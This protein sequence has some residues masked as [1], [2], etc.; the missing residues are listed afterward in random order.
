[1]IACAACNKISEEIQQDIVI[2]DTVGFEIPV[3]STDNSQEIIQNIP[4]SFNLADQVKNSINN[5]NIT[6][7]K[8]T[9]LKSMVL[10]LMPIQ[11]KSNGKIDSTDAKN[12]FNNLASIKF[13]I[14]TPG[15][16]GNLANSSTPLTG[17]NNLT[18]LTPV[19]VPD[20]L[21]TFLINPASKYEVTIKAKTATTT[22]M[23]VKFAAIY[24]ITLAK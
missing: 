17:T 13:R 23:F 14:T 22:P 19:I 10:G 6:Q 18:P 16:L 9:K 4:L 20:S 5:F 11:R 21:K 24:T 7:V 12:N 2:V 3:L 1:M 8:E 15:N